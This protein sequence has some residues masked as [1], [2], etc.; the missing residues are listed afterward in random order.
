M[1][2][3]SGQRHPDE[4][5]SRLPEGGPRRHRDAA[6]AQQP[7]RELT[8][9][10]SDAADV[11]PQVERTLRREHVQRRALQDGQCGIA[12]FAVCTAHGCDH[13][14][15]P[16]H[17][18]E[19]GELRWGVDARQERLL[20]LRQRRR[21]LPRR[22]RVADPPAGHRV[23]LR[24]AVH[25]HHM[26]RRDRRGT[27]EAVVKG[28]LVIALV[29]ERPEPVPLREL[30]QLGHASLVDDHAEGVGR[31]VEHDQPRSLRDQPLQRR[32]RG[33]EPG[34][35][36]EGIGHRAQVEQ[37]RH[38]EEVRPRRVGHQHFVARLGEREQRRE[39]ALDRTLADDH[40]FWQHQ[41]AVVLAQ[42]GRERVTQLRDA[43]AFN[44]ACVP[45]HR[46][47]VRSL[48]DVRWS[49]EVWLADLQPDDVG[50]PQ[51]RVHDLADARGRH[52]RCS[53]ID[54]RLLAPH[55]GDRIAGRW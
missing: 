34:I 18:G 19:R 47:G 10:Q 37:P 26:F 48:D 8:R 33:Q 36:G 21:N 45:R 7:Q 13:L 5:L 43:R 51:R 38:H 39:D 29:G 4:P 50:P 22:H 46:R 16:G 2:R 24:E 1:V 12:P 40:L 30:E 41:V 23:R 20:A 52:G 3:R 28:D 42:L 25:R 17:R 32:E 14:L 27:D 54:A 44:I 35:V 31:R 11:D 6:L 15:R 9:R 53:G 55:D 49:W